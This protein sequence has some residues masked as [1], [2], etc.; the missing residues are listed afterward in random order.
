[1]KQG[2]FMIETVLYDSGYQPLD[3]GSPTFEGDRTFYL[4]IGIPK[5]IL[6][7]G[8]YP[9]IKSAVIG[10]E[11]TKFKGEISDGVWGA[12]QELDGN[13]YPILDFHTRRTFNAI[14]LNQ[15]TNGSWVLSIEMGGVWVRVKESGQIA[16]PSE[17][18]Q[19][20]L[21]PLGQKVPPLTA[22][23][24]K[25]RRPQ[26][27]KT[28]NENLTLKAQCISYLSNLSLR[29]SG[30][31]PFWNYLRELYDSERPQI[32]PD[33]TN[34]INEYLRTAEYDENDESYWVPLF[35]HS[36]SLGTVTISVDVKYVLIKN[37]FAIYK[38]DNVFVKNAPEAN[39]N[40][41]CQDMDDFEAHRARI[42]LPED[43]A[44]C[45]AA[46]HLKGNFP[47][48]RK[49]EELSN[50]NTSDYI[51]ATISPEY[52]V[53]QELLPKKN[54]LITQVD[55]YL[56]KLSEKGEI[57]I[58]F[59]EDAD[60]MPSADTLA[61]TSLTW[62]EKG[63]EKFSW[64]CLEFEGEIEIEAG[65]RYWIVLNTMDGETIW[66]MN[67]RINGLLFYSI[68]GG[69]S[70]R[71]FELGEVSSLRRLPKAKVSGEYVP[72]VPL[73]PLIA[74]VYRI[75]HLPRE[76]E[77][78]IEMKPNAA[79]ND[80][81]KLKALGMVDFDI[82]LVKEDES[83]LA[84]KIEPLSFTSRCAGELILS[85]LWVE[86]IFKRPWIAELEPPVSIKRMKVQDIHG[87]GPEFETTLQELRI[88]YLPDLA[89]LDY[90]KIEA[91]GTPVRL[92]EFKTKA[93]L[94]LDTSQKIDKSLFTAL[95]K[96]SLSDIISAPSEKLCTITGQ[97][98]K[99]IER[100]KRDLGVLQVSLDDAVIRKLKLRDLIWERR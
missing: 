89:E 21:F 54:Y 22:Q 81:E 43:A 50:E 77:M 39:L 40:F 41:T 62:E 17:S 6:F 73:S 84:S 67:G 3:G 86:Y 4:K 92:L 14:N 65:K 83:E 42:G 57:K 9:L 87:V 90:S 68:E 52:S 13:D 16:L 30:Q 94:I 20:I 72:S 47:D 36:D 10:I 98:E 91:S 31:A 61:S 2:C 8:S 97:S 66:R 82:T 46:L 55:L 19:S 56:L 93:N 7:K 37:S 5:E 88:Q 70:W 75:H 63:E 80:L 38:K 11:G 28:G 32:T 64:I 58:D 15:S 27:T 49:V 48:T 44:V 96:W 78:P 33:F 35:L 95:S 76:Y 18:D 85:N 59:R 1:M 53:A 25:V 60:G 69:V 100:L 71:R 23:K 45:K 51:G 99:T 74:G 24:I 34:Q 26:P 12:T 79:G 29:V